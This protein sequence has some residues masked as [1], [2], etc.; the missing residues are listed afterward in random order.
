VLPAS[1][2]VPVVVLPLEVV[3]VA[4]VV[5]AAVADVDDPDSPC[6]NWVKSDCRSARILA[7]SL[8]GELVSV[9]AAVVVPA[10]AA[11]VSD[12]PVAVVA[13]GVP[14][15]PDWNCCK[16]CNSPDGGCGGVPPAAVDAPLL[17]EPA[18]DALVPLPGSAEPARAARSSAKICQGALAP[19]V[20]WTDMGSPVPLNVRAVAQGVCRPGRWVPEEDEFR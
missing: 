10:P 18:L 17:V 9:V 1:V 8:P 16:N 3:V 4:A 12:V 14:L 11:D 6:C 7:M 5:P 2:V 13:S 15:K 20:A 19:C